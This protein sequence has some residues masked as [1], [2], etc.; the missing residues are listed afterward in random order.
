MGGLRVAVCYLGDNH[1][2]EVWP[3]RSS[4]LVDVA[5]PRCDPSECDLGVNEIVSGLGDHQ[6]FVGIVHP[7][8]GEGQA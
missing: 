3:V 7:V 4:S 1:D 8:L 6:K 2:D 5:T